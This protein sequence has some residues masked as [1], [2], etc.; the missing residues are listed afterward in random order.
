MDITILLPHFKTGKMTAYTISKLLEYKGRHSIR[1]I[2]IDNNSGDGSIEYLK[3]FQNDIYYIEYPK[4]RLQSHGIAFDY[5]LENG[6]VKTDYFLTIESDSFPTQD[7]WLDYYENIINEGYDCGAS[8]LK[9]SGGEYGHPAGS[10]Y[11]KSV[12]Q[13]AKKYSEGIQY[14]YFPNMSM[15]ENF[16]C[17]L[18]VHQSIF[19]NF[20]S[21]P[22]D[23]IVLA[24]GYK[25]LDEGKMIA[26]KNQYSP[27]VNPFHNGMGRFDE[28]IKTYGQ[29]NI[30]TEVHHILLNDTP[31]LVNRIGYEPGQSFFYWMLAMKKR[32]F[33]I[34]VKV[35]WIEGWE[36]RQQ[37][38]TLNECG[39]KHLW[40]ISAYFE[41]N[42]PAMR[43][44]VEP[45]W[46][47]VEELYNSI[48]GAQRV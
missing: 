48:P 11:K 31:K 32:I 45:K 15:K 46:K 21:N 14:H 6:Y 37:E 30:D 39:F 27:V 16:A 23:Y 29:R 41:N 43:E 47:L 8:I 4:W 44:V 38:Y 24:N 18:M 40:S 13:E 9:L 36:N 33:H 1:I 35:K 42:D 7:G 3:P 17:H 19:L 22:D 10:L 5:V 26:K 12:W 34:P 25:G 28:S 20:I 2:V